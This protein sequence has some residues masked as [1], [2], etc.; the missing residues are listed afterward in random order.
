MLPL[1]IVVLLATNAFTLMIALGIR[2]TRDNDIAWH[3][4]YY[5]E[6]TIALAL[7]AD[8]L[9]QRGDSTPGT[10]AFRLQQDGD[11]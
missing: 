9:A 11:R 5:Y 2:R 3:V 8:R 4:D 7:L 1:I 10:S 6:Q